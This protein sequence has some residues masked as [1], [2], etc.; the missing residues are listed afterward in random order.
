MQT[1]TKAGSKIRGVRIAGIAMKIF[2][3]STRKV[4]GKKRDTTKMRKAAEAVVEVH[5]TKVD[6]KNKPTKYFTT[7]KLSGHQI[8]AQADYIEVERKVSRSKNHRGHSAKICG[9]ASCVI[10][11]EMKWIQAQ[12]HK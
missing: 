9:D 5:L 11:Q 2:D 7:Q 1:Q 10:E 8:A 6:G 4:K 3:V 12:K